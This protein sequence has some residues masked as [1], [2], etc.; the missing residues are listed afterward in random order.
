MKKF[1]ITTLALAIVTTLTLGAMTTGW[2]MGTTYIQFG[3]L[4]YNG[5][6][7]TA[8]EWNDPAENQLMKL[9]DA[10]TTGNLTVSGT[11]AATTL[12]GA[13][14]GTFSDAELNAL[15]GLTSAADK[16]PY[17]TGS[18]TAALTDFTSAART[19]LDDS[20]T[21]NMRSTLGLVIGTNVQ[22]ADSGL[23]SLA[24]LTYASAAF[25]KYTAADTF[26]LDTTTYQGSD[27]QLTDVAGLTPSDNNVIIGNGA[28][29]VTES[30]ATARTSLGLG[31]GVDVQA[32]DATLAGLAAGGTANTFSYFSAANTITE[33]PFRYFSG[34]QDVNYGLG[35]TSLSSLTNGSGNM[36]FG[37]NCLTACTEGKWNVAMGWHALE[38][39]TTGHDS[40]A[41][42]TDAAN[43]A[44]D[45][46]DLVAIG[47]HALAK[48]V[49][50]HYNVAVGAGALENL[51]GDTSADRDN[52]AIGS[53]ALTQTVGHNNVGLGAYAG[54][55]ETGSDSFY[56][57]A[58]DR[59]NT[60][61]DKAGALLYGI[62][63]S[64]PANQTLKTNSTFTVGLGANIG[65]SASAADDNELVV[66][67]A[68]AGS[69]SIQGTT[70][71]F[72]SALTL[73]GSSGN[74]LACETSGLVYDA[75]NNRVGVGT[76][77]PTSRFHA[78]T[79]S[80]GNN[81]RYLFE[82]TTTGN[83]G[84]RIRLYANSAS[85]AVN[86]YLGILSWMGKNDA[87]VPEDVA[88]GALY[89]KIADLTDGSEDGSWYLNLTVN[90][91]DANVLTI[92]STTATFN[93]DVYITDNCS[94]LTFTDRT[95]YYEGDAVAELCAIRAKDVN[96]KA[97][98][99]H[100]SLPE[101]VKKK[102]KHVKETDTGRVDAG[103][104]SIVEREETIQDE[105]DLGAMIS[106]LT[107][108]VQQ[109]QEQ[110]DELRA[111][112]SD[113]KKKVK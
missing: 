56:V 74:S 83:V 51:D 21:T 103:G 55:Y 66:G 107:V 9:E 108:A 82:S 27:A 34:S 88:Y 32:Y 52:T 111:E 63:S 53:L 5:L 39:Y 17:F 15:A 57:D 46:A 4:F 93:D 3:S 58:Y 65:S 26:T 2:E 1:L 98:I 31:I 90:G 73:A 113:L 6:D 95:P 62:F 20:S 28:N 64:T 110:N 30:G 54:Q 68:D 48:N 44:T 42:G 13:F 23:T 7:S 75:S 97:Q 11:V 109:L 84:P 61:G 25:V 92:T 35:A 8:L 41:I 37:I 105:R 36:A 18:G 106:M 94:A 14:S 67:G 47:D 76:A 78:T 81:D 70:G 96:G 112:I 45:A 24:G 104:N 101:F 38:A 43:D 86:D 80:D 77:A 33:I 85:P 87:A 59:V 49:H 72:S 10:G 102:V 79:T 29:F 99:D 50:G 22:A 16:L 19:L 91:A 89:M 69:Y 71:Y 60:A 12:T 40:V 100:A